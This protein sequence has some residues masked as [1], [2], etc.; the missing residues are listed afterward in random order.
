MGNI[1]FTFN[2]FN[3]NI[4]MNKGEKIKLLLEENV[5]L[6]K[7]IEILENTLKDFHKKMNG[8][9]TFCKIQERQTQTEIL[10]SKFN[11][12]YQDDEI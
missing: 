6:K 7:R 5:Q 2:Y 1:I 8:L 9:L 4:I 11:S 10:Q 3:N 12:T